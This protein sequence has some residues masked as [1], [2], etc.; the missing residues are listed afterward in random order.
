MTEPQWLAIG[1]AALLSGMISLRSWRKRSLT[2]AG[3][4]A[5]FVV[6]Y[7]STA[8]GAIGFVALITFF[9]SSTFITKIGKSVKAKIEQGYDPKG[10]RSAW[11]VW[12]NG[13][14][15]VFMVGMRWALAAND[16]E[17]T[18][19]A[20]VADPAKDPWAKLLIVM[21]VAHYAACQG[22]TWSSELGV[23]SRAP[24]RLITQPWRHVPAGT[25]GGVSL[26][27]SVA[28]MAG[29]VLLGASCAMALLLLPVANVGGAELIG[30][31]VV[32]SVGG[33]AIDSVLGALLQYSGVMPDGKI[34]NTPQK[35]ASHICGR[36]ILS[37]NAVNFVSAALVVAGAAVVYAPA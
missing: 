36:P 30:V 19:W 32:A 8:I 34:A 16:G 23:L 21:V 31:A 28:A 9:V 24:P 22:D 17:A 13:G 15:V 26:V 27:G 29:G 14:A 2:P 7:T 5:A 3:C 18:V 4:F 37:N 25:N 35:S 11:Q 6:G 12:C 10:N 33:S 1:L 20:P